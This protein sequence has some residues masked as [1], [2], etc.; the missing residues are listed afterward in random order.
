MNQM[1]ADFESVI[2]AD[3]TQPRLESVVV[4][5]EICA[6]Q[7]SCETYTPTI[8]SACNDT[9]TPGP[10]NSPSS[11]ASSRSKVGLI[12]GLALVYALPIFLACLY[13][14][15]R[16]RRNSQ[17]GTRTG[18]SRRRWSLGGA[19]AVAAL[20]RIKRKGSI[21][22]ISRTSIL[23][24][25]ATTASESVPNP[26]PTTGYDEK[27]LSADPFAQAN[28]ALVRSTSMSPSTTNGVSERPVSAAMGMGTGMETGMWMRLLDIPEDGEPEES[29]IVNYFQNENDELERDLDAEF[30]EATTTTRTELIH[31]GDLQ[32]QQQGKGSAGAASRHPWIARA[33]GRTSRL[34]RAVSAASSRLLPLHN[35]DASSWRSSQEQQEQQKQQ[36]TPHRNN[37]TTAGP[38]F[39]EDGLFFKL[40]SGDRQAS[41]R[42]NSYSSISVARPPKSILRSSTRNSNSSGQIIATIRPEHHYQLIHHQLIHQQ[43]LDQG[44]AP[45]QPIPSFAYHQMAATAVTSP[46]SAAERV[47]GL[48]RSRNNSTASGV[49]LGAEE[50]FINPG[51][52][53]Q[54]P[55][56][57]F[58]KDGGGS[59][60][61]S[62]RRE[63][64]Q[65]IDIRSLPPG[66][67]AAFLQQQLQKRQPEGS[68]L[69]GYM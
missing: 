37:T 38:R 34:H 33:A 18:T 68:G 22:S 48:S 4:N 35:Q 66:G 23:E 47:M 36:P 43:R 42:A 40:A 54:P 1:V 45:E 7:S 58:S 24:G 10:G 56:R 28:A 27:G 51:P 62:L 17:N 9:S 64:N 14:V 53:P 32:Q 11:K 6:V 63:Y 16:H 26:Y 52:S 69:Y 49:D 19:T 12:V 21:L 3:G 29:E 15:R 50:A 31:N 57:A 30:A 20:F 59:G 13:F 41:T 25:P 46:N 60:A 2:V 5:G 39:S 61:S 8:D 65:P 67:G 44:L 55:T